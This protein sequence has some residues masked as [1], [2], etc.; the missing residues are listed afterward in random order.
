[1]S[2]AAPA[3]DL[4]Y[5][6]TPNG[7][8]VSICLEELGLP[9]RLIRVPLDQPRT[10]EFLAISPNGRIPAIVDHDAAEPI[11]IFE[12]GAILLYLAERARRLIP[13]DTVG[14]SHVIQWLMWQMAGLGPMAG[15]NGHFRLYAPEP[16]PYAIERYGNEVHR[17]YGVLDNQ[18]ARTGAFI[19]GNYSIAD[20]ACFPWIMTH[21]KQGLSLD[22]F[23]ALQRWFAELRARPQVQRGLAAGKGIDGMRNNDMDAAARARLFGWKAAE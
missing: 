3:I 12:S 17:L 18:L 1:M 8:K 22:D 19:A 16:V 11:A 2:G 21:K 14:R 6:E 7:W 13:A 15:Q 9:Y 5:A 20:I 10:P 4:H 23:P